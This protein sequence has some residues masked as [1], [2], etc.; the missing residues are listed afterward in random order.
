MTKRIIALICAL[1]MLIPMV[2]SCANTN[3][4]EVSGD[5]EKTQGPGG[6]SAN[7]TVSAT[8]EVTTGYVAPELKDM[9]GYVYRNLVAMNSMW[10]PVFFS[11]NGENGTLLNDALYR[12]EAF[13]EENYNCQV[14]FILDSNAHNTLSNH[15]GTGTDLCEAIYLS[16]INTIAAA[17]NGYVLDIN[18]LEGLEL[19]K[20]W[21]DQRIQKEYLIG[22]RLF[23]LEGDISMLDDLRSLCVVFNKNLYADYKYTD[24]YGSL[25]D[26]VD[27]GE[28]T[29]ETML[30]MID[31][32]TTDPTSETGQWGMLSETEAPYYFFLGRGE[33]TLTN[34]GGELI[35]NI[36]KES[37]ATT[38]QYT[39]ELV[40]NPNVMIVNNGVWFGGNNVWGNANA[41]FA[42]GNVL[43][44]SNALSS[45][46]AYLDMEDDYGILPIPNKGGSTEYYCYVAGGTHHPLSFPSNLKDVENAMIMT[47]A[48]AYF[49]RFT[50][51]ESNVSLRDAFY[52]Q[53]ADYRLARSHEDTRMLDIFFDSKT[54]DID[55]AASITEFEINIRTLAKAGNTEGVASAIA[56][57]SR[58][59]ERRLTNFL[60]NLDKRYE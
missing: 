21:W 30:K 52:Y 41:T 15:I 58:T 6:D 49:S 26:L 39:M 10:Y 34:E 29:L 55:Q 42:S 44:R 16:G 33:K 1:L 59:A 56:S 40:K 46:N 51:N 60:E 25:Y 32:L 5:G 11:E 48:T 20:P 50:L 36:G 37:V 43:F 35:V 28:W 12:R 53:L 47:E 19:D 57:T 38:I 23:T 7:T 27:N 54:F 8:E 17:K 22:K 9:N 24:T 18:T 13:L 4:P 3:D 45:V 31:G 2:V 14:E